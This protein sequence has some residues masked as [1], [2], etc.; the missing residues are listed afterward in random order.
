[1]TE[2]CHNFLKGAGI[3]SKVEENGSEA[4]FGN[5]DPLKA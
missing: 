2:N 4:V 5:E 1:M 3:F